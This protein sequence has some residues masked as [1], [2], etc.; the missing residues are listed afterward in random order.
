[1]P[2]TNITILHLKKLMFMPKNIPQTTTY[3]HRTSYGYLD[4]YYEDY[5]IDTDIHYQTG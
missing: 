3:T 2:K 4:G 1:M 5:D